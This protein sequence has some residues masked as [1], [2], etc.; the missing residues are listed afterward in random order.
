MAITDS[1]SAYGA[2]VAVHSFQLSA[3]PEALW[4]Q[5]F[6][7]ITQ[8]QFDA[9]VYFELHFNNATGYELHAKS[10]AVVPNL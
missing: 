7:K 3:F 2:F 8:Q 10:D 9:S 1:N 5:I 6:Q 4:P